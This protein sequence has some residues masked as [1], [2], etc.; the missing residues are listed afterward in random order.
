LGYKIE[1]KEEDQNIDI[2][3]AL[4]LAWLSSLS[5]WTRGS[6]T[7]LKTWNRQLDGGKPELQLKDIHHALIPTFKIFL[8]MSNSLN[9]GGKK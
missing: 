8:L 3:A 7:L 9:A 2:L 5:L 1:D 4:F 6:Q